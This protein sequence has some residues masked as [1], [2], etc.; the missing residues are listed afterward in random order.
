LFV[1]QERVQP[2]MVLYNF[3]ML[4]LLKEMNFVRA[5]T[6]PACKRQMKITKNRGNFI[7]QCSYMG[8]PLTNQETENEFLFSMGLSLKTKI[9][10]FEKCFELLK[11]KP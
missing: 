4:Y 7:W 5:T 10:G 1:L 9:I 11:R 8:A 3:E 2:I 6:C